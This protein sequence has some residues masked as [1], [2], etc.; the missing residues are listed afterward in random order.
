MP[1]HLIITIG[2]PGCGKTTR[3]REFVAEDPANRARINRDDCRDMMFGGWTGQREHEDAVT[4]AS[5]AALRA[6]LAD[7]FVV[8][9]DDTNLRQQYRARLI[10][11]GAECGAVLS[12]WDMTDVPLETCIARDAA[13]GVAG[14]RTVGADVIRRMHDAWRDEQGSIQRWNVPAV[15]QWF[16]PASPGDTPGSVEPDDARPK[17]VDL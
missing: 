1:G 7:G 10:R 9:C 5:E 11:A 6:L 15:D 3:A 12:V 14:G 8:V 13:R 2:L 17:P 16:R 4:A